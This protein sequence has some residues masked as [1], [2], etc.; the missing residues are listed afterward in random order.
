MCTSCRSTRSSS[1]TAEAKRGSCSTSGC[2]LSFIPFLFTGYSD[3]LHPA[4]EKILWKADQIHWHDFFF[5]RFDRS[6]PIEKPFN[7]LRHTHTR[8]KFLFFSVDHGYSEAQLFLSQMSKTY[9]TRL[10]K[11][12]M[13]DLTGE[14]PI[15][16]KKHNFIENQALFTVKPC[17]HRW[18]RILTKI[19]QWSFVKSDMFHAFSSIILNHPWMSM[20]LSVPHRFSSMFL[21][22]QCSLV[23]NEHSSRVFIRDATTSMIIDYSMSS[24]YSESLTLAH[25]ALPVS[26]GIRV[27]PHVS[28]IRPFQRTYQDVASGAGNGQ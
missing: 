21:L 18:K 5:A 13:S 2:A 3:E 24:P 8:T 26:T 12:S 7:G 19:H 20:I 6:R 27:L 23:I 11:R 1:R 9:W 4:F 28:S 15:V 10:D 14:I 25:V 22:H 17:F 16:S